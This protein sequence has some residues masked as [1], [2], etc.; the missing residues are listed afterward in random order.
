MTA[1]TKPT[2]NQ[3]GK[4]VRGFLILTA[5]FLIGKWVAGYLPFPVP[6][7]VIGMVVVFGLL[8]LRILPLS[9]VDTAAV[10]LLSF[11]GLF[12]VPYGVGIVESGPLI[13]EWGIEIIGVMVLT[14]VV[15]FFAS[16]WI[17][18]GLIKAN[19]PTDE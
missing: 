18:Q 9:W 12:Y 19:S 5:I 17:F 6:G 2:L 16:G 10:W 14:I 3:I 7:A 13:E 15:V 1:I 8:Q 11:L 4:G